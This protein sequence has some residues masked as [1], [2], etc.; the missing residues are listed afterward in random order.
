[1]SYEEFPHYKCFEA[2]RAVKRFI[3]N[4]ILDHYPEKIYKNLGKYFDENFSDNIYRSYY[5]RKYSELFNE[6]NKHILSLCDNNDDVYTS[7]HLDFT[8]SHGEIA[9]IGVDLTVPMD[10]ICDYENSYEYHQILDKR[11]YDSYTNNC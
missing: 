2:S 10:V 8:C 5:D 9:Y 6:L 11:L 3:N 7:Y 4:L 1:M